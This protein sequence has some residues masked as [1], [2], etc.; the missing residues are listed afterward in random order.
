MTLTPC[1]PCNCIPGY[2]DNVKFKQDVEIIL[3][4]ILAATGG[5]SG[6][7]LID[8]QSFTAI[9]TGVAVGPVSGLTRIAMQ[10]SAVGGQPT[11]WS[12]EL[13]GSYDGVSYG[14]ILTHSLGVNNDG[15]YVIDNVLGVKYVKPVV[16]VL[17]LGGASSIVVRIFGNTTA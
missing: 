13:Y 12:V 14:R 7:Q 3:C 2:I 8:S 9:G 10:V 1:E 11:D 17:E 16:K 15:G 4:A 5:G 6:D